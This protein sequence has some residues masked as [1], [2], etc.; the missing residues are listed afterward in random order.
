MSAY[1]V[2]HCM[3]IGLRKHQEDCLF[4]N[5]DVV[6]ENLSSGFT[7]SDVPGGTALFAVCDGMGGHNSGDWASTY[8]CGKI[9]EQFRDF[10]LSEGFIE[11]FFRA[12]Q[13]K[14]E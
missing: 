14:M 4:L 8:V 12:V 10:T 3:N 6:Q 11:D 5:G 2:A 7:P 9:R 13:S 1:R